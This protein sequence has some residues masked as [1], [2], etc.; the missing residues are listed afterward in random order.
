[1][2]ITLIVGKR[3][4]FVKVSP[5]IQALLKEKECPIQF[6]SVRTSQHY[7]RPISDS[8][9]QEFNIPKL[10]VNLEVGSRTP[11]LSYLEYKFLIQNS[12]AVIKDSGEIT[13]E[14]ALAGMPCHDLFANAGRLR[15]GWIP[16]LWSG[17]AADQL[18]FKLNQRL[19]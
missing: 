4:N 16:K 2:H 1:M 19:N 10:N 14:S 7:G 3:P 9:F 11:G 8:L 18:D 17:K 12:F 6:R 5:I 15:K 13:Q